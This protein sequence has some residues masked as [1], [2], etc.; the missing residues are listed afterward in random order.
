MNPRALTRGDAAV[1]VAAVLLFIASFLP[2]QEA[3]C[4]AAACSTSAW[5]AGLFPVLPSIY[6][7]GIAAAVLILVQRLQGEAAVGRQVL[8]LRLDQWG[9]A[10]SVAALWSSLW[11]LAASTAPNVSHGF[12]AW[13]GLLSLLIMAGAAAAG[14]L[15]PA[16][17]GP[18][19]SEK[20]P[21]PT[22]VV[23]M[24][25]PQYGAQQPQAHGYGYQA[26]QP[27][28]M[29]VQNSPYENA[30]YGGQQPQAPGY[31][32]QA[33]GQLPD[34]QLSVAEPTQMLPPVQASAPAAEAAPFAP[35]WFAV[36]AVRPLASQDNPSGPAIGELVP[37][38]WYL[39]VGEHGS[40]LV[41]Q[42]QDGT[43]GLLHDT[44]GIQRG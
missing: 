8:G 14:P 32:Y 25:N 2:Y 31:G 41:A 36:P 39:A 17:Q 15:V 29:L 6:L 26:G 16:L 42:L 11:G 10:L 18:L 23:V 30:P 4:S 44:S 33:A 7:L 3:N 5:S 43:Q 37:G 35:Y 40:T 34:Q 19:L 27:G 20:K 22:P 12:G 1:A 28:P 9:I 24:P 13:L 38:T 21:Q